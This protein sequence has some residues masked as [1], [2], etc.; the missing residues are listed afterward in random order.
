MR[1]LVSA[2]AA[3]AVILCVTARPALAQA[4]TVSV[5]IPMGVSFLVTNVAATSTGGPSPMR[6]SFSS[7]AGFKKNDNFNVSVRA[8]AATFAGPGTTRIP[9]TKVS[10]AA[11]TSSG[12]ATNGTLSSTAY[13]QVYASPS[14]PSSGSVDL[15]WTLGAITAAGLRAGTHTLTVRWRLEAL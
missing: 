5:T 10:W 13:S 12:A 9:A 14:S 8:D 3:T 4:K 1:S 7:V 2:I 6:I 11:V 15:T